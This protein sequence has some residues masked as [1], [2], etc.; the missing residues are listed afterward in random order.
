MPLLIR[1]ATPEDRAFL[2]QMAER[3]AHFDAPPAWRTAEQIASGDRRDML[4]ALDS[5]PAGSALMVA[6][7][8]GIRV[9]CLHVLTKIDFFT[10]R[11]HGH[12]SVIAVSQT[13]EGR[14]VGR[15]LMAW[16]DDW[17]RSLG[18][19]HLTLNLFPANTRARAL[20]ERE[21]F[22]LDMLSMRKD[23]T[24]TPS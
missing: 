23:L 24:R 15:A 19:D 7:L 17:A 8:G 5:P 13:A 2:S 3:L 11:P 12:I 1:P 20:Y 9:G 6:E 10:E 22:A 18:H 21:G 4:S 14:G 16:A